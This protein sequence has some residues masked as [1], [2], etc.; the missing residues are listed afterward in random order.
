MLCLTGQ[1]VLQVTKNLWLHT[2]YTV[3]HGSPVDQ[4]I[5]CYWWV[6]SQQQQVG[7]SLLSHIVNHWKIISVMEVQGPF[8]G[9]AP[10]K[11]AETNRVV[12]LFQFFPLCALGGYYLLHDPGAACCV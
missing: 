8:L 2:L 5:N 7:L 11:T 1:E 10:S 12:N 6:G 4:E 9:L 3:C